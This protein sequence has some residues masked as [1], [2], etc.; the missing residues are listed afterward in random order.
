[1]RI[2]DNESFD[3]SF[4]VLVLG[5]RLSKNPIRNTLKT[6]RYSGFHKLFVLYTEF[7]ITQYILI[8]V[9]TLF[10]L[11]IKRVNENLYHDTID[12]TLVSIVYCGLQHFM[13]VSPT[14]T[15]SPSPLFAMHQLF[16]YLTG[17]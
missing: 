2:N 11:P 12:R 1:M 7:V 8:R 16:P 9:Q 13:M 6:H 5:K 4:D 14:T 10:H 3:W 17:S 15:P